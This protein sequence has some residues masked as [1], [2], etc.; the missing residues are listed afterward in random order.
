MIRT[1]EKTSKG[2]DYYQEGSHVYNE[3]NVLEAFRKALT[4]RARWVDASVNPMKTMVFFRGYSASHFR[5][6]CKRKQ[7]ETT[8]KKS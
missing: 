1:H 8:S 4:T 7:D 5:A 6:A 3:L 2:K